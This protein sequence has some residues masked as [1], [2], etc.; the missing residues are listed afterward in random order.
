MA[1]VGWEADVPYSTGNLGYIESDFTMIRWFTMAMFV[2]L[3]AAC[4]SDKPAVAKLATRL[5]NDGGEG[6]SQ[7]Y[8]KGYISCGVKA[9]S[10]VPSEKIDAALQAPDVPAIWAILGSDTLNAYVKAC[11]EADLRRSPLPKT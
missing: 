9:L 2:V 6:L 8:R 5:A 4:S 10:S 11:R 7:E 3:T 1:A